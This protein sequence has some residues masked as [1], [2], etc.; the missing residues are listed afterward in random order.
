MKV[1]EGIDIANKEKIL[2]MALK[3]FIRNG[4][5][6][7]SLNEIASAV[8]LTKGG[9]Y[10]YFDSKD[11]LYYQSIK[12]FFNFD[13]PGWLK[14]NHSSVKS[15]IQEGFKSINSRKEWIKKLTN[16]DSD[17]AILHF[18]MFLY[19]ATRRHPDLQEYI[20]KHDQSKRKILTEALKKAQKNREIRDDIDPEVVAFELDALLQQLEYLSFVN[21]KIKKDK[22]M[23]KRLFHNYWLRLKI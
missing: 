13:K 6:G 22:D 18:Y 16:I 5:L 8:G 17:D 7:T 12:K 4:Y 11:D 3:L 1:V 2:E 14:K 20:D 9:V 23:F 21:P 19:D 10:H 15:L